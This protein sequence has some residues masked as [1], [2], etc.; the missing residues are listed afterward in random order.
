MIFRSKLVV[1][2]CKTFCQYIIPGNKQ[3]SHITSCCLWVG[4]IRFHVYVVQ[5]CIS[6][7]LQ[8][9]HRKMSGK[10]LYA[11]RISIHV[12]CR[13]LYVSFIRWRNM[14]MIAKPYMKPVTFLNIFFF[15]Q[16]F[17]SFSVWWYLWSII[18]KSEWKHITLINELAW[19]EFKKKDRLK[20]RS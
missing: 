3:R 2:K 12:L 19:T 16:I 4:L 1:Y 10:F 9:L 11:N 7:F 13:C 8:W 5:L 15:V 6:N 17:Y 18:N 20:L 14:H